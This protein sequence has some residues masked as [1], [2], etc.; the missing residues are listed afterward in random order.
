MITH[1]ATVVESKHRYWVWLNSTVLYPDYPLN[2]PTYEDDEWH[3]YFGTGTT[4]RPLGTH[5][6]H[7]YTGLYNMA[8]W[9]DIVEL[10]T[11]GTR[12]AYIEETIGFLS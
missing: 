4:I 7:I 9:S 6:M 11:D 10:V 2:V 3:S 5:T 8:N 1:R 12:F